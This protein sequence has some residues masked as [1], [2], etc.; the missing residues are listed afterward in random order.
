MPLCICLK[1]AAP[2]L[3]FSLLLGCLMFQ[4]HA[5]Q[6]KTDHTQLLKEPDWFSALGSHMAA[7]M[8]TWNALSAFQ[9]GKWVIHCTVFCIFFFFF[10][11]HFT[12]RY[13]QAPLLQCQLA[14]SL[15]CYPFSLC[16][17]ARE[18]K[19]TSSHLVC[20][21]RKKR[22]II[23]ALKGFVWTEIWVNRTLSELNM[24]SFLPLG[25]H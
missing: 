14:V 21:K 15:L 1:T 13:I 25:P 18:A 3:T 16:W 24:V 6:G 17:K 11:P 9:I 22:S 23:C 2:K 5:L 4:I 10:S 19:A 7:V 8:V 20:G 12:Y